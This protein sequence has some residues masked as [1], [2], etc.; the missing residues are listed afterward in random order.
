MRCWRS[1]EFAQR[2]EDAKKK[3]LQRRRGGAEQKK[4][5]ACGAWLAEPAGLYQSAVSVARYT[6]LEH[7]LSAPLRLL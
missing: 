5:V 7:T 4:G 1:V 3:E 6:R 2:R